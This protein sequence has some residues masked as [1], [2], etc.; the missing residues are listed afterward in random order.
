MT[1]VRAPRPVVPPRFFVT[2]ALPFAIPALVTLALV[3]TVGEG[4]PRNIPPGSGLKLAGF[5]VTALTGLLVWRIATRKLADIRVRKV[6]ALLCGLTG[7]MGWPVW[8]VGVLPSINGSVLGEPQTVSMVLERTET[9]TVSRSN[10]LNH[11]AHLAPQN[12]D[13]PVGAGR[14]FI[15]EGIYQDL[16]SRRPRSV[17]LTTAKGLLGAQVVTAFE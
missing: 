4:W 8:S 15:P 17:S 2:V 6:A 3:F 1:Q 11:W 13:A 16:N 9:T 12:A 14:Y 7:L 10:R 5:F